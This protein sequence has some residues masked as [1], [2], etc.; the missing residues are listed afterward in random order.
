MGNRE[1][2]KQKNEPEEQES[3]SWKQETGRAKKP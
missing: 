1:S 3:G 2:K